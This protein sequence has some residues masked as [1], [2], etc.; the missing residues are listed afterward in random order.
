MLTVGRSFFID[1]RQSPQI[2]EW[3]YESQSSWSDRHRQ[4]GAKAQSPIDIQRRHV[5]QSNQ[6]R[7]HFY[8]YDQFTRFKIE[9]A[10]HT[11]K[12][13]P[14]ENL[15]QQQHNQFGLKLQP[16]I[17]DDGSNSSLPDIITADED[18]EPEF[19]RATIGQQHSDRDQS[20]VVKHHQSPSSRS[21]PGNV[22]GNSVESGGVSDDPFK[23]PNEVPPYNG[24]PTIKLDWLDDGNNEYK[25]RDIH[26]HWGERRD[27]GS[28]H[29]IDGRR[30]AMEVCTNYH[31]LIETSGRARSKRISLVT[32]YPLF[33]CIWSISN[34]DSTNPK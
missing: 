19:E 26:F 15:H 17:N 34:T 20:R 5:I 2:H 21:E 28:E 32:S 12:L 30:A 7:L 33:R 10:H 6:L 31:T 14:I 4:C 1:N 16:N 13:N 3:S 25:L 18:T 11:V 9:N 22:I 23:Q 29:A 27:N 24:A 8:N